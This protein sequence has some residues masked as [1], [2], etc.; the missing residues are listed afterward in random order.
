MAIARK[1]IILF[2][3][4]FTFVCLEA[5]S[6]HATNGSSYAGVLGNFNNPAS[7]VNSPFKWDFS[8]I[9]GQSTTSNDAVSITNLSVKNLTP[10][11]I[12]NIKFQPTSG[13]GTRKFFNN[14]DLH[15]LNVRYAIDQNQSVSFGIRVRTCSSLKTSSFDYV[16]TISGFTSFL[17]YNTIKNRDLPFNLAAYNEAWVENDFT[18]ARVLQDDVEKR[19]SGGITLQL[20]RGI[21][22]VYLGLNNISYT[23]SNHVNTIGSGSDATLLYSNTYSAMDSKYTL[24][25]NLSRLKSAGK[26]SLGA[27][28]GLEYI[29]KEQVFDEK[30]S[31]EHY[32]WK[33]G[34]SIM[35]IGSNS[36]ATSKS[37]FIIDSAMANTTDTSLTRQFQ[38]T[39]LDKQNNIKDVLLKNFTVS[40]S[41]RP[42]FKMTLPTRLVL[43]VDRSLGDNFYVNVLASINF[44]S[45]DVADYYNI[46]TTELNQLI[47]TPRWETAVWGVYAPIQY[48]VK[49]R[50]M[51]GFAA[52]LGPLLFGIHNINWL[53]K[54]KLEQFD[55]GGYIVLHFQPSMLIHHHSLD[56]FSDF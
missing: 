48:T 12:N 43:S 3:T 23:E 32:S 28:I 6:Y 45:R 29:V 7:G 37:S 14:S 49:D 53:Q 39:S 33:F 31:P 38:S 47:I 13:Y 26:L 2:L 27:S 34:V 42:S 24:Y 20:L 40:A 44:Y 1:Y 11:N 4:T 21:S 30:Y 16:D 35:D 19:L 10:K 17:H 51:L 41:F 5:Q 18:Y 54:T 56:C 15:F 8:V 25:K 9:G 52:K 55:G 22:G 50:L 46:K 36:F